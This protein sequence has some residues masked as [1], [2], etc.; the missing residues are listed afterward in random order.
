VKLH[1]TIV[2]NTPQ[3]AVDRAV[4]LSRDKYCSVFHSLR[5]DITLTVTSIIGD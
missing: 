3:E 1:F 2:G 4:A 5:E